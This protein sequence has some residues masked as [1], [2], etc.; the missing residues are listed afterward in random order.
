MITWQVMLALTLQAQENVTTTGGRVNV[1]PKFS[2]TSS[3]VNSA[4]VEVGGNVGVGNN[5]PPAPLS[6][7]TSLGDKI[8]LYPGVGVSRYG[9]GIQSGTLVEYTGTKFSWRLAPPSGDPST[10][11]EV[12]SLFSSGAFNLFLKNSS[13][14]GFSINGAVGQTG[15][16]LNLTSSG[17]VLGNIF[18]VKSSGNI[19]IGTSNPASKLSVKGLI[20]STS[21]GFKFP[22]NTVQTTATL[23]GPQ[24]PAGAPGAPGPT[25]PQGPPGPPGPI[26]GSGA[27]NHV[28]LWT[29]GTTLGNSALFQSGGNVGIGTTTPGSELDVVGDI[30]LSRDLLLPA[31]TGA[32][33]GVVNLGGSSFIHACCPNST[34]NT[35]VG[36]NAG[37][38][39][40]SSAVDGIGDNTA[41]GYRAM[42]AL[43]SG[44]WNTAIGVRALAS[45]T[46]GTGNTANGFQA[47][48]GNTGINNTAIGSG[49]L[50]SGNAGN[51]NTGIGS[52]ALESTDSGGVSN[53]GESNTAIGY[54]AGQTNTTGSFN[55]FV[56]AQ[57]NPPSSGFLFNA[58]AI[59]ACASVSS[60]NTMTLG[61]PAGGGGPLCSGAITANTR[62]GID[63]GNPS[64][65]LT[66]L[67]G[68]GHAISDGWDVYSSRRWK[69]NIQTLHDALGK[70]EQLRGVEYTYITNGRQEI[71]VIAEEVATVVPEVVTYEENGKDARGVDYAR[72]TALLIEAVKQQ[73]TEINRQG[74]EINRLESEVRTLSKENIPSATGNEP[75]ISSRP[76]FPTGQP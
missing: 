8:Q 70:V 47:L 7:K 56:G 50:L 16:Y 59:G 63:V 43:T 17:E 72:L 68:G 64:N 41:M 62:I 9:F 69:S 27:A 38:F 28:P 40:A 36:T 5:T 26:G 53:L 76:K 54:E 3:V 12:A 31:T 39:S 23:I 35:F 49:A 71:G 75:A 73:Q 44:V 58:T 37:N 55:T 57:A 15:N 74:A 46:S 20:Q 18:V 42:Q 33:V 48:M 19:G 14:S 52:G 11:P 21:G 45:N 24:G 32:G 13:A 2:A 25:G 6:F 34:E 10:G 66:V 30:N 60:S 29:N 1:V 51:F 65:I 22:D 61:A 4:L 67:R